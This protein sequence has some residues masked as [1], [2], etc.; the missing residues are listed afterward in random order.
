MGGEQLTTDTF[1]I[2]ISVNYKDD[3]LEYL[4]LV[5]L[6]VKY[7][8]SFFLPN[9]LKDLYKSFRWWSYE[10]EHPKRF[11]E[12]LFSTPI[13]SVHELPAPFLG[14]TSTVIWF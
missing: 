13:L 14:E 4:L 2:F 12:S 5:K 3:Y 8:L 7:L 11:Q 1:I 6:I 9:T 10:A